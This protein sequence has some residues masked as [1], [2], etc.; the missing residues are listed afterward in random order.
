MIKTQ[1]TVLHFGARQV[2]R[3]LASLR[4]CQLN[5]PAEIDAAIQGAQRVIV[6]GSEADLASVL[7]RLMKSPMY[8][9]GAARD[10]PSPVWLAGFRWCAT[11]PP[12]RW[13]EPRYG[14]HPAIPPCSA[15]RR[16][17]TTSC[18]STVR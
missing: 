2:H 10:A 17:W 4:C 11:K 1:I 18:S 12:P 13:S 8:P 6:I 15:G 9:V 14:C 5:D 16:W 7:T 3:P